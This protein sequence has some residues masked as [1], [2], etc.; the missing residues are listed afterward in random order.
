M[1]EYLSYLFVL[2]PIIIMHVLNCMHVCKNIVI[3]TPVWKH[4]HYENNEIRIC[5]SVFR[6]NNPGSDF[7]PTLRNIVTRIFPRPGPFQL[8]FMQIDAVI[9]SRSE[10][11]K[12]CRYAKVI[13]WVFR[14]ACSSHNGII[15]TSYDK[16]QNT[17]DSD[18]YALY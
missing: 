3:V 5:P 2:L 18:Y 11:R 14:S 1:R 17:V 4:F 8:Q 7:Q 13:R 10:I 12:D 16:G 9:Y 6:K 15:H